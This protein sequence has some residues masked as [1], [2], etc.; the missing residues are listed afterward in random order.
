MLLFAVAC[1]GDYRGGLEDCGYNTA[2][3]MIKDGLATGLYACQTD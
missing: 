3:K 2:L 1:G